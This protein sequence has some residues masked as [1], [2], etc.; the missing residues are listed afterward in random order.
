MSTPAQAVLELVFVLNKVDER[1]VVWNANIDQYKGISQLSGAWVFEPGWSG[2]VA[3]SVGGYR[4]V[5]REGVVVEQGEPS[6]QPLP[7]MVR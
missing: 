6:A 7:L 1:F 2:A 3:S 5:G 4:V